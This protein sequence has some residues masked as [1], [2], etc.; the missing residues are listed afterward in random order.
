MERVPP[1][2]AV[3]LVVHCPACELSATLPLDIGALLWAEIQERAAGLVRDVHVLASSY[4][5]TE[6]DVLALS[7]DRR[8]SYLVLVTG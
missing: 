3:D 7:P 4:G 6:A 1:A 5:W 2:G 8:A